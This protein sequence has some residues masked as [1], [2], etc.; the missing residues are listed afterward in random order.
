MNQ[1]YIYI[2]TNFTN[3]TLYTGVTNNLMRRVYQHKNGLVEGFTKKYKVHKLVYYEETESIIAA[4]TREKQIK[5]GSRQ[6]KIDLINNMNPEWKDLYL[7][8]EQEK[9][10]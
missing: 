10:K 4:I 3:T 2:M 8:I 7:S 6:D 5:G 1:Y 9:S